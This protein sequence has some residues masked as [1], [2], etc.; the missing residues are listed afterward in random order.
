MTGPVISTYNF[1]NATGPFAPTQT[2]GGATTQGLAING[3]GATFSS[4]YLNLPANCYL[5]AGALGITLPTDSDPDLTQTPA[6]LTLTWVGILPAAESPL[7]SMY[8][9]NQARF[10]R[11][12]CKNREA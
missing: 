10:E 3:S 6:S 12:C 2:N 7:V 4:G 1:G 8:E 11:L 5:D 9:W